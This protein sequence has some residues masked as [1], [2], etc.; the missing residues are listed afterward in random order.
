M[1][2]QL[3]ILVVFTSGYLWSQCPQVVWEDNFDGNSLDLNKWNFQ[4]GDGCDLGICGWGNNELQYYK[5]ENVEVSGGTLKIIAKRESEQ[6]KLYTSARITSKDKGDWTFGRFEAKMKTPQGKGLWPAFWMLS[7][8]EPYGSWPQS[9]EID[10]MELVGSE[11]EKVHGTIHFG[12]PPPN[13]RSATESYSLQDGSFA[14]GFHTFAI[15]WDGSQIRWIVDDFVYSTK[16]NSVTGGSKWPFDHDFHFLLNL[17]VGGNWPGSPDAS[18]VFPQNLEVDYVRVYDSFLPTIKGKRFVENQAVAV[19]YQLS[20]LPENSKITWEAPEDAFIIDGQGTAKIEVNWGQAGGF[21]KVHYENQCREDSLALFVDVAPA[22]EQQLVLEN[23]DDP[24][25]LIFNSSTGT[26]VENKQNP[27]M[28]SINSSALVGEYIRNSDELFD[29]LV[30]DVAVLENTS[31]FIQNQKRFFI[32]VFTDAPAGTTIIF[33]LENSDRAQPDNY[34]FGRNSRFE[35]KTTKQGQWERLQL[36]F[37]DQPDI[38][39]SNNNIDQ[40]ILLFGSNTNLGSTFYFD[41][42][43]IYA[44]AETVRTLT[45]QF[46]SLQVY[47]NPSAALIYLNRIPTNKIS[48]WRISNT[49][50]EVVLSQNNK[51]ILTQSINVSNLKDGLYILQVQYRDGAL[52]TTRFVKI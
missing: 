1:Q 38:N 3:V 12:P 4:L 47:P 37:L 40:A 35:T 19:E 16:I 48:H 26:L 2:Y 44:P 45:S 15:E 28:D 21:L 32:D 20:N 17:A 46:R 14:D 5:S 42:L 9:G 25:N 41:N 31:P 43:A 29:I 18:T 27:E 39:T 50:G 51:R 22:F 24:A 7:S 49:M 10:I 6:N 23:F 13:N 30:Y 36:S 11:P 33:Q 52:H 34:P 8:S